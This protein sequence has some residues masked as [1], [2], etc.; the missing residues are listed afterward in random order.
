MD[1][2]IF[3][4]IASSYGI[5]CALFIGMLLWQ[6]KSNCDSIKRYEERE[7]KL[8]ERFREREDTLRK[9]SKED[10]DEFL[11]TL[12]EYKTELNNMIQV[13]TNFKKEL[14]RLSAIIEKLYDKFN[15]K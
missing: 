10:K 7:E 15:S 6:I 12:K 4:E 3:K 14:E 2:A 1:F 13:N 8:I 11:N 9:E 5:F